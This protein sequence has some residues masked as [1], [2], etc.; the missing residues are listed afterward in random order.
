MAPPRLTPGLAW[1]LLLGLR[2]LSVRGV[3]GAPPFGLKLDQLGDVLVDRPTQVAPVPASSRDWHL[4][5]AGP[6]TWE[7]R[8]ELDRSAGALL[9]LYLPACL[10][11]Q[12]APLTVAHLGQSL[13]GRIATAEGQSH[14]VTGPE[15]IRHLHR[16]RAL[17]DAVVVGASTVELD[18]PRLTTRLVEGPSPRRVVIDP[19]RRLDAGKRVFQDPGSP[20]LLI[21]RAGQEAPW[22]D[23]A[24]HLEILELPVGTAGLDPNAIAEALRARG[25]SLIF[26]EGGGRTVTRFVE[27]AAADRLQL[28]IAPLLIGAGRQGLALA[29][30]ESL[31]DAL[32]PKCRTFPMGQDMLFD[33]DLR[34]EAL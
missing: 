27:T 6:E 2:Q 21:C 9:D 34:A 10:A 1:R 14:C 7:A 33:C 29:G 13:D 22:R 32:R 25:C 23:A 31:G 12:D 24:D 30:R 3:V 28:A 5:V 8:C 17:S 20:T 4:L 19:D 18:D 26:V 15:N 11:S 16:M